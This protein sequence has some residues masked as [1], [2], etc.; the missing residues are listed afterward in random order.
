MNRHD[1]HDDHEDHDEEDGELE[2]ADIPKHLKG[3]RAC[4][5]CSLVKSND[6]FVNSGCENCAFLDMESDQDRVQECTTTYFSGLVSMMEPESSWV[7]KWQRISK[8]WC[9]PGMY[10]IEVIGEL[11]RDV[12]EMVEEKGIPYQCKPAS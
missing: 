10:A 4:K 6:Q 7:A 11:P 1:D 2:W 8:Y 5:R 9:R 3:L 12:M